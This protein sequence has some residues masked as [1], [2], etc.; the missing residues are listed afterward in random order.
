[1]KN[2]NIKKPNLHSFIRKNYIA[3]LLFVILQ[4]FETKAVL[5]AEFMERR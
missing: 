3:V 1:M 2:K 5:D 4:Q